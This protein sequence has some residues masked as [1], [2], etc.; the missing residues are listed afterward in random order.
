MQNKV[1]ILESFN[2]INNI[3]ENDNTIITVMVENETKSFIRKNNSWEEITVY[4]E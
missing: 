1:L 4:N 2:E 3:V